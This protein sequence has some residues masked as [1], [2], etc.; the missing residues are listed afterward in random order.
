MAY[1]DSLTEA[2]KLR[3]QDFEKELVSL[4]SEEFAA[5]YQQIPMTQELFEVCAHHLLEIESL[6][7]FWLLLEKFPDHN[8]KFLQKFEFLD[9]MPQESPEH[10]DEML[11][12]LYSKINS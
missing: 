3:F 2:E 7:G 9:N 11:A 12:K 6:S 5:M 4:T 10:I 8:K 1:F